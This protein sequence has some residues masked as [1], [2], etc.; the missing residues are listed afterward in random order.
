MVEGM[1]FLHRRSETAF[2]R[3]WWLAVQEHPHAAPGLVQELARSESVAADTVEIHQAVGWGRA[4]PSWRDD[5][6]P[7]IA[8]DSV[9]SP[10]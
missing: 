9:I 8:H 6:P 4:H 5:D 10:T 7:F 3:A 1:P 2:A